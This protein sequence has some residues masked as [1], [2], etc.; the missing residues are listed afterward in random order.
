MVA[1]GRNAEPLE[2]TVKLIEE[3]G[4]TASA[5]TADVTDSADVARS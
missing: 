5:V 2:Q 1:A 4:G 3:E